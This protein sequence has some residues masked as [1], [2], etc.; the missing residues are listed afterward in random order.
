MEPTVIFISHYIRPHLTQLVDQ[1]CSYTLL[2]SRPPQSLPG[3]DLLWLLAQG[4]N[5]GV[6]HPLDL[7]P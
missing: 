1:S 6:E 3:E 2:A 5:L 4:A 7:N